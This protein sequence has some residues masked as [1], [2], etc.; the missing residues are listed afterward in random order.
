LL[1]HAAALTDPSLA[2]RAAS[3]GFLLAPRDYWRVIIRTKLAARLWPAFD[4]PTQERAL[5]HTR[6]LW[7]EPKLHFALFA[8]LSTAEGTVAVS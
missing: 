5:T 7:E 4:R 1:A 3:Q 2:R 8:L 6:L